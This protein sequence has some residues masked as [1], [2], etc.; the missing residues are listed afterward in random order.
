MW[1][2]LM[3]DMLIVDRIFLGDW[4]NFGNCCCFLCSLNVI[5]FFS[6]H[7]LR[8]FVLCC[9]MFDVVVVVVEVCFCLSYWPIFTWNWSFF[10]VSYAETAHW[11]V[12]NSREFDAE[13]LLTAIP[14][15]HIQQPA[16]Q[17]LQRLL[18]TSL[19]PVSKWT[20]QNFELVS[21]NTANGISENH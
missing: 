7:F 11:C 20:K 12:F 8:F 4:L 16:Q 21:V 9:L 2:R 10:C 17:Q 6:V 15:S 3:F 13:W 14:R 18:A 5:V 1:N 19:D